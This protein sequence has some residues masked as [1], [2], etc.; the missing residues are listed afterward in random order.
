M[1]RLSPA[2][3]LQVKRTGAGHRGCFW[4]AEH[5]K[6]SISAKHA[7]ARASGHGYEAQQRVA[8]ASP[9]QDSS[10]RHIQKVAPRG[11]STNMKNPFGEE[12]KICRQGHDRHTQ[13]TVKSERLT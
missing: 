3:R 1:Q 7:Q 4:R 10:R 2:G 5:S 6:D 8:I 12:I 11:D 9:S 13:T